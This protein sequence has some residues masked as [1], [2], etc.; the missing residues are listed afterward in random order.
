[1]LSR[2]KKETKVFKKKKET[3][4]INKKKKQLKKKLKETVDIKLDPSVP[5]QTCMQICH[6]AS[7]QAG[8]IRYKIK[9]IPCQKKNKKSEET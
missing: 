1:M 2:W 9:L 7:H 8:K 6:I 5:D 4:K 3:K